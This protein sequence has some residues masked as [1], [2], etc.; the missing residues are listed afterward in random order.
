MALIYLSIRITAGITDY[1]AEKKKGG[2][3]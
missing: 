1:L 2:P 3:A